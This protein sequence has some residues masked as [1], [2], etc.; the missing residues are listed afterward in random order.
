MSTE[1]TDW[2]E[3]FGFPR[4]SGKIL[5]MVR[6]ILRDCLEPKSVLELQ[7]GSTSACNLLVA[8]VFLYWMC[9]TR[10][11]EKSFGMLLILAIRGL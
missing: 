5:R 2:R 6:N 8:M 1:T 9:W 3:V 11:I 10:F 4:N 7:N